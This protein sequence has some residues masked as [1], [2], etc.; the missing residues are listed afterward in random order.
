MNKQRNYLLHKMVEL[1][2]CKVEL[3]L[4]KVELVSGGEVL[5]KVGT[6]QVGGIGTAQG[7]TPV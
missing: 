1:V 2:L 3:V 5:C 6:A 4:H 7:G